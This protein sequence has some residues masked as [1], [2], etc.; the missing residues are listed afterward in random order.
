MQISAKYYFSYLIFIPR[1]GISSGIPYGVPI[2]SLSFL[3]LLGNFFLGFILRAVD[4]HFWP[5]KFFNVT[6]GM[7]GWGD[8]PTKKTCFSAISQ[9]LLNVFSWLF[10]VPLED[11][12]RHLCWKT[13]KKK[14]KKV[15]KFRTSF[16]FQ[17]FFQFFFKKS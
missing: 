7:D 10:L 2:W 3:Y 5:P 11:F 13:K 9:K 17:R 14:N 15:K 4:A 6:D 1:G 12:K 8:G 16:F